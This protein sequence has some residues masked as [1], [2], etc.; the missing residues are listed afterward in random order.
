VGLRADR[1][2]R[3]LIELSEAIAQLLHRMRR[4]A[5]SDVSVLILGETGT[6][7]ELPARS[8]LEASPR[9][10]GPFV[11]EGCAAFGEGVLQSRPFG[12]E[13]GASTGVLSR[14]RGLFEQAHG[15]TLRLD[16][17]AEL[18]PRVQAGL[19]RVL[20][21]GGPV[22]WGRSRGPPSTCGSWLPRTAGADPSLSRR[23]ARLRG[24]Q[25]AREGLAPGH[26]FG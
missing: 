23:A 11:A 25:P 10:S 6:G 9:A 14:H 1:A 3:R 2:A 26:G 21:G 17:I 7:K 13:K 24:V 22:G 20:Q 8:L 5:R 18:P 12:H 4:V 15:G 19:L 16:E